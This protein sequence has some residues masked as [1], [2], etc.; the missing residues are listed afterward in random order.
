MIV[1]VANEGQYDLK[2]SALRKLDEI[3]NALLDAVEQGDAKSFRE[4]LEA[5]LIVIR[6]E[7]QKLPDTDLR[8]S[9]LILP[10]A[11]ITLD[12]ARDLFRE[13]PRELAQS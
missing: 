2:D 11:D 5:V 9:M 13:Y 4:A 1:R 7:G 6:G 3:D 10:P 8:E 12:E